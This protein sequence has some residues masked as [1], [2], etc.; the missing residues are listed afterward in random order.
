M[1]AIDKIHDFI[2]RKYFVENVRDASGKITSSALKQNRIGQIKIALVRETTNPLIIRST[3]PEATITILT[4]DNRELVEIPPRKLKSREKLLGLMICREFNV[5]DPDVRYN[6]LSGAD[7]LNNPNS[8]LFGDTSTMAGD[9]AG[10]V[11]RAVYDWAYSLRDVKEIT[12]KLQHNALSEAGTMIDETTG[13]MRQSL[14]QT[15]YVLPDT[16]FPHFIT[17]DNI[18]P[19]LFVHLLSCVLNQKRYGAQTTTNANNMNNHLVAIGFADFEKP[20]NSYL[21]SKA[22]N[23]D[24]QN[25]APTLTTVTNFVTKQMKAHYGEHGTVRNLVELAKWL[26]DLWAEEKKTALSEIYQSAKSSVT[27]YLK[28][29]KMI[30]KDNEGIVKDAIAALKNSNAEVN[31]ETVWKK[32]C[33]I[34]GDD[35][36]KNAFQKIIKKQ[37][38]G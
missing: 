4:V 22:W 7:K 34:K 35:K 1:A 12:D 27:E 25:G 9:T 37:L 32:V 3:D 8:V 26:N 14:Y 16:F 30:G 13:Q 21:I 18:T 31:K 23:E 6:V 28:E 17:V 38:G 24:P 29:I 2:P 36:Q 20:I 11:S 19:E 5:V 15:D 33:E 10:L